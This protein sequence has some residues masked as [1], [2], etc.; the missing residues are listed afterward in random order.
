MEKMHGFY[1]SLERVRYTLSFQRVP[2]RLLHEGGISGPPI[3]CAY[4]GTPDL[5]EESGTHQA[6]ETDGDWIGDSGQTDDTDSSSK[7]IEFWFRCAIDE[8]VHEALEHF[9][10]D[11][12]T[13]LD[14]HGHHE[15]YV[16]A[17][18]AALGD[19]LMELINRTE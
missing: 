15:A 7:W 14:P 9:H 8:A 16:F 6:H 17:A 10:V 19:R 13:L 12:D 1:E 5:N 4:E 11:G 2:P 18:T 3:P